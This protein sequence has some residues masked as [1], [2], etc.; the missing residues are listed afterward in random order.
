MASLVKLAHNMVWTR[1]IPQMRDWCP[2]A[3]DGRVVYQN[4]AAAFVTYDEE[5]HVTVPAGGE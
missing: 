3:L 5:H 1:Q 4:S 2:K